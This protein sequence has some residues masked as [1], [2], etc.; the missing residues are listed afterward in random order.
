L[1]CF[2]TSPIDFL[3]QNPWSNQ[4]Q[5]FVTNTPACVCN[6]NNPCTAA[7]GITS[8]PEYSQNTVSGTACLTTSS[9]SCTF[10]LQCPQGYLQV[11]PRPR[12]SFAVSTP[13]FTPIELQRTNHFTPPGR[14]TA[15][16]ATPPTGLRCGSLHRQGPT[17]PPLASLLS[18]QC[19]PTLLLCTHALTPPV[20]G[21]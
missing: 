11:I 9:A 14:F 1:F 19:R 3:V 16:A 4:V 15:L 13:T 20:V 10:T 17:P 6:N 12:L 2:L 8:C 5:T 21:S 7:Q 18:V